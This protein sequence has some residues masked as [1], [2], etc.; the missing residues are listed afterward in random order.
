[1]FRIKAI[2]IKAG[3][4]VHSSFSTSLVMLP[5]VS[6]SSSN[7]GALLAVS[8][9]PPALMRE[10]G[11]LLVTAPLAPML[12]LTG[13]ALPPLPDPAPS[14]CCSSLSISSILFVTVCYKCSGCFT[15]S[16]VLSDKLSWSSLWFIITLFATCFSSSFPRTS[17]KLPVFK[18]G[19]LVE[20]IDRFIYC[21][22]IS[23]SVSSLS[24]SISLIEL[25]SR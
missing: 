17:L 19:R 16:L 7:S 13:A 2:G 24:S 25:V 22:L 5:S 3:V 21:G 15:I 1:M 12:A 14:I 8:F 9:G 10:F 6:S 11:P 20:W 23:R 4:R 18:P